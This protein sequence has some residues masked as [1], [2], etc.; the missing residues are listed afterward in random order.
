MPHEHAAGQA[1]DPPLAVATDDAHVDLDRRLGRLE[2]AAGGE[3]AQRGAADAHGAHVRLGVH[4]G[5]IDGVELFG[6]HGDAGAVVPVGGLG[7]EEAAG[8]AVPVRAAARR[9]R[10]SRGRGPAR[11]CRRRGRAAAPARRRRRRGAAPGPAS[12]PARSRN[13]RARRGRAAAPAAR[14]PC[15]G[16]PP[17]PA[18]TRPVRGRG[19]DHGQAVRPG[20][21]PTRRRR[22][23]STRAERARRPTPSFAARSSGTSGSGLTASGSPTA[24]G[25]VSRNADPRPG[26]PHACSQPPCRRASSMLIDRPSPLP[27][28]RAGPR[29]LRPPEAVEHERGL[30]RPQP[31]TVVAH[32]HGHGVVV[33]GAS[34]M[35]TGRPSPWS[36]AFATRLRTIRSTRRGSTSAYTPTGRC[37]RSGVP[38]SSANPRTASTARVTTP[39]MSTR[40]AV[41]SATPASSLLISSRSA[42]SASNRSSSVTSSSE[43]RRSAGSSW[44][45]E[46]CRTSA[47]IRTV[48]SGVRSSW[49]TSEVNRRCSA[50]NSS[51]WRIWVWMLPAISL[52]DSASRATSSLPCTGMRS[53]RCPSANRSAISAACRTGRTTCRVTRLAIPASSRSSTS[54]P[55]DQRALHQ[56]ERALLGVQREQQVELQVPARRAHRLADDQRR[57]LDA[58]PRRS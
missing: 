56:R 36:T 22:R 57:D 45:L 13:P 23:R 30:P 49:L 38:A 5:G 21:A 43:L 28:L 1:G 53:S 7:G 54:P 27:P 10:R 18:A 9:R 48:V 44:S 20:W 55:D 15:T 46:A 40:S 25:S 17:G 51:S 3:P 6:E 33:A 29:L 39:C 58:S 26:S 34:V 37:S 50:P 35:S 31:D 47:A 8:G 52:Y 12:S 19:P 42:S 4:R 16:P 24:R 2:P 41:R 32:H 14:A 11:C